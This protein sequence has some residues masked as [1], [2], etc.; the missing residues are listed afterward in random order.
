LVSIADL[1]ILVWY[2]G[3]SIWAFLY[4]YDILRQRIW[5][6]Y[7]LLVGLIFFQIAGAFEIG[8][9]YYEGNWE[10]AGFPSDLVNG[11]FYFFNF[12][13]TYLNALGMR[14]KGGM[15]LVVLQQLILL[16]LMKC[17][18]FCIRLIH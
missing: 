3:L 1:S 7:L 14:K 18:L 9:H 2:G 6:P 10:L 5:C 17:L 8:N 16:L 11:S 13:A 4:K 12:G 15:Y